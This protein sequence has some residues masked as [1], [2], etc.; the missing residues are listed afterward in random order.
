MFI[1]MCPFAEKHELETHSV[2]MGRSSATLKA[3]IPTTQV[4]CVPPNAPHI[5]STQHRESLPWKWETLVTVGY[6]S[7][8]SER[9]TRVASRPE[10]KITAAALV[11]PLQLYTTF[12]LPL[13]ICL[14]VLLFS[15]IS[16]CQHIP[17]PTLTPPFLDGNTE[18]GSEK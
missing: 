9:R 6:V 12:L 16:L 11:H 18:Q 3:I 13:L 5:K 2:H 14:F 17:T 7:H 1:H 8:T 4:A 10:W 15:L